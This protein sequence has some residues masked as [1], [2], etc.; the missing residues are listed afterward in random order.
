MGKEQSKPNNLEGDVKFME[1]YV[2]GA[3]EIC[4]RWHKKYGFSGNLITTEILKLQGDLKLE[5]LQTKDSAKRE[6]RKMEYKLSNKWLEQSKLRDLNREEKGKKRKEKL[7]AAALVGPD[8]ET[9]TP[10]RPPNPT[11]PP[12]PQPDAAEALEVVQPPGPSGEQQKPQV[13]TRKQKQDKEKQEKLLMAYPDL[14]N[15]PSQSYYNQNL[16]NEGNLK[17]CPITEVA[18]PNPTGDNPQRTLLV[19]RP[20]TAEDRSAALK[21]I[22]PLAEGPELFTA[23]I[24]GL[25]KSFRLNGTEM[26]QCYMQLCGHSWRVAGSFTGTTLQGTVLAHDAPDLRTAMTELNTRIHN[27][28][29]QGADYGKNCSMQTKGGGRPLRLHKQAETGF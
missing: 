17:L 22:P 12:Q 8:E 4:R 21:G 11:A 10:Y 14:N 3:G 1:S 28:F 27:Q 7:V 26:L 18:N 25:Q 6:K 19:Y 20:W 2:K 15:L 24:D 29:R 13:T 16:D 9:V 23:A 5:L